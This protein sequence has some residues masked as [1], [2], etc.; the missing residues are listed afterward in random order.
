MSFSS[1]MYSSFGLMQGRCLHIAKSNNEV[2][3]GTQ[4]SFRKYWDGM[5]KKKFISIF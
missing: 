4:S 2:Y 5:V 3:W 1:R